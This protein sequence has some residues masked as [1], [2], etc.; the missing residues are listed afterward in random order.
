MAKA[1]EDLRRAQSHHEAHVQNLPVPDPVDDTATN[2]KT[3]AKL[4]TIP[5]LQP[6]PSRPSEPDTKKRKAE[7]DRASAHSKK[8]KDAG[9]NPDPNQLSP[10]SPLKLVSNPFKTPVDASMRPVNGFQENDPETC[11]PPER[12]SISR[13]TGLEENENMGRAAA[14]VTTPRRMGSWIFKLISIPKFSV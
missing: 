9:F 8:K 13:Q 12:G 6:Q 1:Q 7:L 4:K 5:E 14:Q 11:T 3:P 2:L 10:V